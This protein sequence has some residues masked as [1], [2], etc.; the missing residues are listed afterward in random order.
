MSSFTR[1]ESRKV[2]IV[3]ADPT[4]ASS[5]SR[6]LSEAGFDVSVVDPRQGFA[7]GL[8]L[9]TYRPHVVITGYSIGTSTGEPLCSWLLR[10]TS[11]PIVGVCDGPETLAG[12]LM[13][14][15]GADAYVTTPISPKELVSR[16]NSLLRRCSSSRLR[17]NGRAEAARQS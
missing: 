12:A 10:R 3:H 7:E 5:L 1:A 8:L 16:I 9:T 6:I 2:L 15:M 13:L 14:E 11:I 4:M 17:Q